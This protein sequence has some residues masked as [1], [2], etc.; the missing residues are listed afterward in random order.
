MLSGLKQFA[1]WDAFCVVDNIKWRFPSI[2]H[3]MPLAT[4]RN[5]ERRRIASRVRIR[6]HRLGFALLFLACI[7]PTIANGQGHPTS[8]LIMHEGAGDSAGFNLFV[9]GLRAELERQST[10]PVFIYE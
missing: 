7:V 8:I 1:P 2:G 5:I 10:S 6:T 4:S 3:T 9:S